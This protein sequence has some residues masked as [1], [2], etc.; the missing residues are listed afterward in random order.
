MDNFEGFGMFSYEIKQRSVRSVGDGSE[1]LQMSTKINEA[2]KITFRSAV[3]LA[4]VDTL[5]LHLISLLHNGSTM[6]T[7]QQDR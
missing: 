6:I 5:Y 1:M 3:N 2:A 4:I 7:M